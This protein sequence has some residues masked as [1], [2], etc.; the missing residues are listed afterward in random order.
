[1]SRFDQ[2]TPQPVW[3]V[4][5]QICAIPHPSTHEKQLRD[6]IQQLCTAKGLQTLVDNCGNLIVKKPATAGMENRQTVVM[7]GHLDMVPQKNSD[8]THDFEKDAIKTRIEDGWLTAQGTTLGADN[9]V[10]VAA[11]LAV[12][13]SDDIPHGPLEM[14][15]T[16]EEESSMRGAFGLESGLLQASI[17]LNLDTEEEGELYVGCA[18]GVDINV[19]IEAEKEA[20]PD[21]HT[22]FELAVTGLLGGHSGLDI[23]KGRG[24]ANQIANRFL[25]CF[26]EQLDLRVSAFNGGTL[27]NAIPRESFTL[28]TLPRENIASVQSEISKFEQLISSEL[29]KTEHNLS[30][31]LSEKPLPKTVLSVEQQTRI[32]DAV[33]ACVSAPFRMSDQF[34]GVVET[35][36][37]LAIIK[38]EQDEIKVQ[39]LT[40][41]LVNSARDFAAES[42][43]AT[44]RLA[45]ATTSFAGAYPGWKPNPDSSILKTMSSSYQDLFGKVPAVKVIHAGLECGLLGEPYPEMD[46][47]SFGPTIR[48]AHSPDER[49]EIASVEKFWEYLLHSLANVPVNANLATN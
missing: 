30:I 21:E 48:G 38:S 11:A 15:C 36:N 35:S 5:K 19:S 34:D 32:I 40:R 10:G 1:M 42:V 18:G 47:I 28:L 3:Q 2:L 45:G 12:L 20:T 49:C 41:S 6:H 37:N 14:L 26:G 7:Q 24:N 46:M 25:L 29:G 17:L 31:T 44:F 4:F 22:A 8:S 33:A 43:A 27:R 9:G 13:L 16:I 39:C 23:D